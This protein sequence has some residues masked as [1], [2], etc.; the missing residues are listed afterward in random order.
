MSFLPSETK[1]FGMTFS[2]SFVIKSSCFLV[3][4]L[5]HAEGG[6]MEP[7]PWFGPT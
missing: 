5:R 1:E 7:F 6:V 3:S 2:F 4:S